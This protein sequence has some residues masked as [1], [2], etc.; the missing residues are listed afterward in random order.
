M[1]D[2]Q[3]IIPLDEP[4]DHNP[5]RE[6]IFQPGVL[7]AA[8]TWVIFMGLM[9]AFHKAVKWFIVDVFGWFPRH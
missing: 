6:P 3:V 1:R 7:Y 5:K 9:F 8:F 2:Q 4:D